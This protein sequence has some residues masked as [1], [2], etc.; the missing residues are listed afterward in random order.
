MIKSNSHGITLYPDRFEIQV[1]IVQSKLSFCYTL[2]VSSQ[3]LPRT[4]V[5]ESETLQPCPFT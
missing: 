2:Y 1:P 4:G 5:I 3:R